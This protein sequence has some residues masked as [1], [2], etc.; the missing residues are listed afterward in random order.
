MSHQSSAFTLVE[1]LLVIALIAIILGFTVPIGWS[2]VMQNDLDVSAT[3]AA[4]TLRRAQALSMAG[5]GGS[6]WGVE[7]SAD[8]ITLFMGNSFATRNANADEVFELPSTLNVAGD[9]EVDFQA[10]GQPASGATIALSN[11]LNQNRIINV[12]AIGTVS[13]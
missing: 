3:M 5:A 10:N 12:N 7:V 8:N 11:S 1:I 2:F 13:Y 6:G 9:V 4:Q